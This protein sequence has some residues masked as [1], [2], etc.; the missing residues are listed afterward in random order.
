M[1]TNA[2]PMPENT[3]EE[4]KEST[5]AVVPLAIGPHHRKNFEQAETHLAKTYGKSP[6]ADD[7]MR[8]WLAGAP[9]W[10]ITRAFEESVL[11]I[12]GSDLIPDDDGHYGQTLLDL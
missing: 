10:E 4:T 3:T 6:P 2:P 7:L 8:L 1:S 9:P 12:S 5:D 11:N